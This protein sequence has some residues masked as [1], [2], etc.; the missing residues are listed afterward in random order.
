M[1]LLLIALLATAG[2][3]SIGKSNVV[4]TDPIRVIQSMPDGS[5]TYWRESGNAYHVP[6]QATSVM[7]AGNINCKDNK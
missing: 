4:D 3:A 1:R 6:A 5:V 7:C 2:C